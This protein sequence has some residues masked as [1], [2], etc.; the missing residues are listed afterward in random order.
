M[1]G[2]VSDQ[3]GALVTAIPL[4]ED[5]AA[6]SQLGDTFLVL[7]LATHAVLID[8]HRHKHAEATGTVTVVAKS[9]TDLVDWLFDTLLVELSCSQEYVSVTAFKVKAKAS[10]CINDMSLAAWARQLKGSSGF[11]PG[12]LALPA[13]ATAARP[14]PPVA[15]AKAQA[16]CQGP[17]EPCTG[18]ATSQGTAAYK[19]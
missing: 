17:G 5:D 1:T 18:R 13:K 8:S 10:P 6:Q 16:T 11:Q 14:G 7:Q 19:S 4:S 2:Q 3:F 12:V 9:L 15:A